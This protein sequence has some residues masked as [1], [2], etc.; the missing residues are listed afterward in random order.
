MGR[1]KVADVVELTGTDISLDKLKV[2]ERGTIEEY[3]GNGDLLSRLREMGLV[4][5]TKITVKGL[6]PLGDPME[7]HV[8]GYR[9]SLRKEDA[10]CIMV[11]P[12]VTAETVGSA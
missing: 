8:R 12:G 10:S 9:L 3:R 7:V 5:G 11:S 4:R 2:G 1:R 6:A